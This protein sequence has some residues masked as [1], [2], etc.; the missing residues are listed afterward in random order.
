MRPVG[1][2]WLGAL[3]AA[4][5]YV[6]GSIIS[7]V[8]VAVR[9]PRRRSLPCRF[10]GAVV[11]GSVAASSPSAAPA[12]ASFRVGSWAPWLAAPLASRRSVAFAAR[13]LRR[14]VLPCRSV[15]SVARRLSAVASCRVASRLVVDLCC[16]R[17]FSMFV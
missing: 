2:G 5:R 6:L 16:A 14:C 3:V 4:V 9:C 15:G 7:R 11:G 13:R 1:F 8:V 10:V 12:V 17:A